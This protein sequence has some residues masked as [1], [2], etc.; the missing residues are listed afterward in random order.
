M[1]QDQ[2]ACR[3][4]AFAKSKCFSW[5]SHLYPTHLKQGTDDRC[6]EELHL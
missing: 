1:I 5:E 4:F 6:K 2:T 3:C